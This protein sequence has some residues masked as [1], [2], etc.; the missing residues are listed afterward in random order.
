MDLPQTQAMQKAAAHYAAIV[1]E[2]DAMLSMDQFN[3]KIAEYVKQH[4]L[5]ELEHDNILEVKFDRMNLDDAVPN[6]ASF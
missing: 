2:I 4:N 1:N 6:L 3:R 5:S